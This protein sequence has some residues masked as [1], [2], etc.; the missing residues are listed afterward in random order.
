M[1]IEK[2]K[3]LQADIE[4][5]AREEFYN[6]LPESLIQFLKNDIFTRELLQF[7][8]RNK[9]ELSARVINSWIQH[10]II[11]VDNV[12]KGRINRFT[13]QQ[14]I[15]MNLV[16]E[17][18]D[19][20]LSLEK[21][22]DIRKELFTEHFKGF[23]LFNFYI[24]RT[25]LGDDQTLIILSDGSIK[26][27]SSK[28]YQSWLGLR[29]V[30]SHLNIS[31]TLILNSVFDNNS[32]E[33]DLNSSELMESEAG[34]AVL[35]FLRTNDFANIKLQ[36]SSGDI[37]LLESPIQF[38]Q[39]HTIRNMIKEKEF[40]SLNIYSKDHVYTIPGAKL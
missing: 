30:P 37:C 15:W 11:S 20:G 5:K 34:L 35:F 25:I 28:V 24:A 29:F 27:M 19:F 9:S 2:L 36:S 16:S 8:S 33:L 31:F 3:R 14:L 32:F 13:R 17:L 38:L 40:L 22:K 4:K 12:D 21:V 39:S 18:R 1:D 23:C 10:G 7:K 26:L 6:D